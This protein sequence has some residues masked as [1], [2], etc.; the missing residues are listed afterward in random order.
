ML[1]PC[2]N[3]SSTH[4][5][6]ALSV[7]LHQDDFLDHFKPRE[8]LG[9]VRTGGTNFRQ[10]CQVISNNFPTAFP[11]IFVITWSQNCHSFG[12]LDLD[13]K[14]I[15]IAPFPCLFDAISGFTTPE[16]KHDKGK[17]LSGNLVIF[18][19]SHVSF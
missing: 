14:L 1:I 18:P 19:A 9:E 7:A 13:S 2:F 12:G 6:P 3:L 5:N 17:L 11:H 8:I 10:V 16:N 15:N 4:S